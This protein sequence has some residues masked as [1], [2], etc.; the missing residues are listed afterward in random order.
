MTVQPVC[1][2]P[3]P[4]VHVIASL[5]ESNR[6]QFNIL[7]LSKEFGFVTSLRRRKPLLFQAAR[8]A[9]GGDGAGL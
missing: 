1:L 6:T 8:S 4:L 3:S 7:T 5:R 9:V 2:D